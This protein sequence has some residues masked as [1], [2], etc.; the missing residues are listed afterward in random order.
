MRVDPRLRDWLDWGTRTRRWAATTSTDYHRRARG[1][2]DWCAA[3]GVRPARSTARDVE[4]WL[5]SLHQSPSVRSSSHAA[6]TAWFDWACATGMTAHNAAREIAKVP[7]RRSVPRSLEPDQVRAVLAVA[8][9][10]GPQVACYVGLLVY[11]A[12]RR[13]EASRLRWVDVEGTDAWLRVFGKGGQER[14]VPVHDK[15]RPLIVRWRSTHPDPVWMFP[16][17]Y[18]HTPISLTTAHQWIRTV[19]DEA[20]MPGVTGHW[21]RHSMARRMIDRG[22]QVP[23]VAAALGHR[24]LGST[25]TYIR[26]RPAQVAAAVARLDF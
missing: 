11:A 12:L 26:S 20:G 24:S 9:R 5:T 10:H 23:D 18:P 7:V 3:N 4:G 6:V 8:A 14:M 17:R 1:W 16:G 15:L 25:M 13:A 22:V 2:L 19:L 21:L